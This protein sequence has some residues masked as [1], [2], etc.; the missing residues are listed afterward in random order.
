VLRDRPGG[1]PGV[2]RDTLGDLA[3]TF[4]VD[5]VDDHGER[6]GV[7][8]TQLAE[9]DAGQFGALLGGARPVALGQPSAR[10]EHDGGGEVGRDAA[11]HRQLRRGADV[12]V[13]GAE[14]EHGIAPSLHLG[15]TF[16]DPG[17]CG[18]RV[19]VQRVVVDPHAVLVAL[20]RARVRDEELEDVVALDVGAHDGPEDADARHRGGESV[21]QAD[22]D[23]RFAG[24]PFGARQVDAGRH[25]TTLRERV[26]PRAGRSILRARVRKLE[27]PWALTR[28]GS[29]SE[30]GCV[31]RAVRPRRRRPVDPLE[32]ARWQFGIVTV[33]HFMM[34]PLTLGLGLVVAVLQTMWVRTGNEQWLRM[35]KFCGKLYL[36]NLIM[37]VATGI[38]Q[39]F[40]FGMAWSEY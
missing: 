29:R 6:L 35:T 21:E 34:V 22:R 11:I 30:G 33:Y 20:P 12:G 39:E 19:R 26:A 25:G 8:L 5:A 13:V 1:Q 23:G 24:A 2:V 32:I 28:A 14:D 15:E 18:I 38:V 37:G 3:G 9:G 17:E 36:D 7:L 40:Q 31:G 4:G 27:G 16:H 10:H